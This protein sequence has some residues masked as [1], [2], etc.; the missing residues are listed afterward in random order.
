MGRNELKKFVAKDRWQCPLL[1]TPRRTM[2]VMRSY[3][4]PTSGFSGQRIRG[5]WMGWELPKLG[6][7]GLGAL[8]TFVQHTVPSV[9][10]GNPWVLRHG[11]QGS[12]WP[13]GMTLSS[14][15]GLRSLM[16]S[17][18]AVTFGWLARQDASNSY[19][20]YHSVP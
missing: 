12:F 16:H 7:L 3:S 9:P 10:S 11:L 15:R 1:G 5:I 4:P 17:S 13:V 19:Y 20:Q 14:A 6:G 2:D 8:D 18:R